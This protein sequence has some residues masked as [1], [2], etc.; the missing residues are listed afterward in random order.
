LEGELE[1][2]LASDELQELEREST[3]EEELRKNAAEQEVLKRK[4]QLQGDAA[5]DVEAEKDTNDDGDLSDLDDEDAAKYLNTEE[6]Y[7]RKKEL[8]TEIN[9]EY[10]ENQ[11]RLEKMKRERPEEYERLRPWGSAAKK[12]KASGAPKSAKN[13]GRTASAAKP[14]V[15]KSSK[16]LNYS[17]LKTLGRTGTVGAAGVGAAVA[18]RP[19]AL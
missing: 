4:R 7:E 9:K 19:P 8:W 6:E 2:A 1:A 15:P 10:L 12:R 18:H 5:Q 16:K 14:P 11:E 13:N 17:V 3:V